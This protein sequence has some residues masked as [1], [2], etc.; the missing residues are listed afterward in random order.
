M[1]S[2][3]KVSLEGNLASLSIHQQV[4]EVETALKAI[5]YPCTILASEFSLEVSV[6]ES[7]LDELTDKLCEAGIMAYVEEI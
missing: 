7:S 2:T 4:L 6:Y 5:N 1:V 3:F